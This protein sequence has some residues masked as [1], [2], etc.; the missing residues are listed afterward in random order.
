MKIENQQQNW[1]STNYPSTSFV[2]HERFLI[3]LG[4][5]SCPGNSA[6]NSWW[7]PEIYATV[8]TK[9][10][11]AL[12]PQMAFYLL[13]DSSVWDVSFRKENILSIKRFDLSINF[14]DICQNLSQQLTTKVSTI[15]YSGLAIYRQ[16]SEFI[17]FFPHKI[18]WHFKEFSTNSKLSFVY[19]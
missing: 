15:D 11:S 19:K 14:P 9:I 10:T 5:V 7:L 13:T 17:E 3:I 6:N 2:L 8:G 12:L 1:L 16:I 4:H 18:A